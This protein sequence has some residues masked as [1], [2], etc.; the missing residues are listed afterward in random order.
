M[1]SNKYI[2]K[3]LATGAV[4]TLIA[5]GFNEVLSAE[6]GNAS[7]PA[8]T[9]EVYKNPTCS[10]CKKWITHLEDSGIQS[11]IRNRR[12][13]SVIKDNKGIEPRYRACHTAISKDGYIFEGHVPAKVIKQFLNAKHPNTVI[14]LSVP[15]MPVGSPGMEVEDKFQPYKILIL[16]SDGT[17]EIYYEVQSYKEQF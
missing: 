12:D 14:G 7:Q 13:L 8:I 11:L 17:N 6:V 3:M 16:K 2:M 9:I 4:V 1:F 10:C 5:I 15:G